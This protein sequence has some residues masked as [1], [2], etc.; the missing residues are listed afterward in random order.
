MIGAGR[1]REGSSSSSLLVLFMFGNIGRRI[2]FQRI[3]CM[4]SQWRD[5]IASPTRVY[6]L[7]LFIKTS[8]RRTHSQRSK[9]VSYDLAVLSLT[10]DTC[11]ARA[12]ARVCVCVRAPAL[13]HSGELSISRTHA[14]TH[15]RTQAHAKTRGR[16]GRGGGGGRGDFIGS[17]GADYTMKYPEP[18]A[19]GLGKKKPLAGR[20]ARKVR[21]VSRTGGKARFSAVIFASI[22]TCS[23]LTWLS[24]CG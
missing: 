8:Q 10:D 17:N 22:A 5:L 13:G 19:R 1:A 12:R 15:A 21:V 7:F 11:D 2:F 6:M 23:A 24:G 18:G 3:N 20:L 4:A 9:Q 16:K 14:R